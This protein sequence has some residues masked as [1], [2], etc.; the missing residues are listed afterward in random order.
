[1]AANASHRKL[2]LL[3]SSPDWQDFA[4]NFDAPRDINQ[5]VAET[6]RGAYAE[7]E[8]TPIALLGSAGCG[9]STII[10]R[11]ALTIA[12][13][14]YPVFFSQEDV[15]P[16]PQ[17]AAAVFDEM[18]RRAILFL[19][20]A[21]LTLN[22]CAALLQAC[23]AAKRPLL[24][25]AARTNRYDRYCAE[26]RSVTDVTEI[27]IPHLSSGD[28]DALIDVLGRNNMLGHLRGMSDGARRAEFEKRAEKQILIA[29]REATEGKGFDQIIES[30]FAEL[31]PV[32]AKLLYLCAAIA[33]A[34][35]SYVTIDQLLSSSEVGPPE[36]LELINRNLRD[37]VVKQEDNP[38]LLRLRHMVIAELMTEKKAPRNILREAYIRFLSTL[39]HD[40]GRPP[41]R[42]S[43][44]ARL[45][46]RIINHEAICR[47]FEVEDARA[48]YESLQDRF[49]D[50]AHFWLQFGSLEL[51]QG[52]LTFA[53]NYIA[54]AES[55]SPSDDFI[56]MAKA[57]LMLKKAVVTPVHREAR[58]MWAEACGLVDEQ[59]EKRGKTDPYPYHILGSQALLFMTRCV[60]LEEK[61]AI[62]V[63]AR[64]MVKKG[65][66]Y[67][68]RNPEL[69][70]LDRE[71]QDA[72]LGLALDRA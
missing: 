39:S 48:I 54:Q 14:G 5:F 61:K 72:Y 6:V 55:L 50:E 71:L 45:Y 26:I 58:E 34:A 18:D 44:V 20:N 67:H 52:D 23:D 46:R 36:A 10:H 19:D 28:I 11:V 35:R 57:H 69:I 68:S 1:V 41:D 17:D 53:S 42:N 56:K 16:K 33:T 29:M 49:K 47:R 40:M 38:R 15:L 21:D 32:E 37:I 65:L 70:D 13:E 62:I 22:W 3:G 25:L 63:N 9:K 31:T 51:T 24:V 30:E 27:P 4:H 60:Y 43:R 66:Q 7:P 8:A 64:N 59:I 2:Y 12:A